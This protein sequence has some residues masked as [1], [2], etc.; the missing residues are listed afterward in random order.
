MTAKLADRNRLTGAGTWTDVG[1]TF[2]ADPPLANLGTPEVPS[3][4]AEFTGTTAEFSF[5]ALDSADAAE[6]FG[7][8]VLALVDHD[9]PDGALIEWTLSDGSLLAART[10]RRFSLRKERSYIILPE[11]VTLN[12][13]HCRI[14]NVA[15]GTYRIGAAFA[16]QVGIEE[17][18]ERGWVQRFQDLSHVVSAGSTDWA[19]A[20]SRKQG[21][22]VVLPVLTYDRVYG[23]PLPG[24]N[25]P[26]PWTG[27]QSFTSSTSDPLL[28]D[29]SALTAGEW[30]RVTVNLTQDAANQ[31]VV[32]AN[33][34]TDGPQALQPGENTVVALAVDSS[35]VFEN[36]GTFTGTLEV[37]S[38]EELSSG[39]GKDDIQAR[40][41]E[42]GTHAPVIY[43]PRTGD[44]Q[45]VESN[46]IYGRF[47][48]GGEIEHL[49]GP[50]HTVRFSIIEQ[51]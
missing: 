11:P 20:R 27:V 4:N 33:I 5:A 34:G 3:P 24:T 50:L 36:S 45:W 49:S 13:I 15:S 19:F 28:T 44:Q 16:G 37:L 9:L 31:A 1:G 32:S 8:Q 17:P 48:T 2:S 42:S 25:L 29:S 21:L 46:A 51:G 30:H 35:L 26:V 7:V 41:D 40:L 43:F 23:V 18:S 14:S 10:W 47:E 39:L 6:S 22:P 38:I 12:T